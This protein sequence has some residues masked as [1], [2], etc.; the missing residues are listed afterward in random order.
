MFETWIISRYNRNKIVV[1]A[2]TAE[3]LSFVN[4]GFNYFIL[5]YRLQL[6]QDPSAASN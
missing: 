5:I 3:T 2:Q 1:V 4:W 6:S